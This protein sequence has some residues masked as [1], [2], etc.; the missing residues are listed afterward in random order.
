MLYRKL[1]LPVLFFTAL[2]VCK[3]TGL[4]MP[5]AKGYPKDFLRLRTCEVTVNISGLVAETVVY[6]E[7]QNEWTD[8]TD[9]VYSFPLPQDARATNFIY[10]YDNKAYRAV[11]QVKEQST[12]PGTGEGGV[13]AQVN[14]YIGKNGI[15]IYLKGIK[16][17]MIQKVELHYISLCNYLQGKCSYTFPL[18]TSDFVKYPLDNVKFNF[19]VNSN[20]PVTKFNIDQYNDYKYTQPSSGNVNVQLS[21]S[22]LYIDQD[23]T[24]NYETEINKLGVDFYSVSGDTSGG[25]FSLF[26]RPQNQ[27]AP[28]SILK[29]TMIFALSSS[30]GAVQLDAGKNAISNYLDKLTTKD[31]FN[32]VPFNYYVSSWNTQP[33]AATAENIANAKKYLAAISPSSGSNVQEA[34]KQSLSQLKDSSFSNSIVIFTESGSNADPMQIEK[35]NT[36]KASIFPIGIGDQINRARLEMTASL[37]YGFTTYISTSDNLNDITAK[38][39]A[40]INQP[41][42]KDV[43]FEYGK[44][45]LFQLLPSKLPTTYAGSYFY[46]TGR[47]KNPGKS[48][49]SIAGYSTSGITAF[50]F[51]LDFAAQKI[52]N[53]FA[54]S[55]WAK[56]MIDNLER[57]IEIYGETSAL[58]QQLI[59]LSLK[60]NI[61]C[62]YT[63]YIAD[64]KT[65]ST[66]LKDEKNLIMPGS[67]YISGNYPNPFNPST[68][69]RLFLNDYSLGKVKFLRVY[70][71]LGQLVMVIDITGFTP[72]WN[73][74]L[75]NGRDMSGNFLPSGIYIVQLQVED[76]IENTIRINLVK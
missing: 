46:L 51:I 76:K 41:I 68:K 47:Y 67:S 28:D 39:F 64:Y 15:K 29:R 30:M 63:A 36:I 53:K 8:S 26:V 69:I 12:N 38:T 61:R 56:E 71:I 35:L 32:I 17:G 20:T 5:V 49:L 40:R 34:L 10:W 2:S 22:K 11:L 16:A 73:E 14:S 18:N 59:D 9:A 43:R 27:A 23:V 52:E 58:K 21:K 31:Y 75:F 55:I 44:T 7:F 24:F 19:I 33:V 1:I 57:Q 48:P 37:N 42:L 72:G 50:D 45:D 66:G 60:Y 65:P 3:A 62:R 13:A 74:V 70:N 54:E 25:H 4:L 6:Q